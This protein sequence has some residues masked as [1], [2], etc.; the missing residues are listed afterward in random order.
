M[1][2]KPI[3][4]ACKCQKFSYSYNCFSMVRVQKRIQNGLKVM[5]Y[6]TIRSWNFKNDKFAKVYDD[7]SCTDKEVFYT[8]REVI[9][10]D[11]YMLNYILG[12]RKYCAKEEPETLPHARKV[13]RR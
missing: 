8:N 7:L 1:I 2:F 5:Q 3:A 4:G 10:Y 9:K 11:E 6:Y 12:A 13:L